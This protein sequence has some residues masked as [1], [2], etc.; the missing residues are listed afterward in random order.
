[1][2]SSF[3]SQ[4]NTRYDQINLI[5][6]CCH[7]LIKCSE[8]VGKPPLHLVGA[9]ATQSYLVGNKDERGRLLRQTVK[10]FH[11]LSEGR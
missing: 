6:S 1:M 4:G 10:L 11:N 2:L 3:Y 7:M 8:I 5:G 9:C